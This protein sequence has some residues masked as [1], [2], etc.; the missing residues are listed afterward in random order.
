MR[1]S[2]A[3][4]GRGAAEYRSIWA[5]AAKPAVGRFDLEEGRR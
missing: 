4:G 1:S 2:A 5:W 3:D